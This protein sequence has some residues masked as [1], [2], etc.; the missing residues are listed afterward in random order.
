MVHIMRAEALDL[1]AVDVAFAASVGSA[2]GALFILCNWLCNPLARRLFFLRLIVFLSVA[3]LFSSVSYI[4]SF[5][6]LAALPLLPNQKG[7]AQK[8]KRDWPE[9][10]GYMYFTICLLVVCLIYSLTVNFLSLNEST[11][12]LRIAG[13]EGCEGEQGG[14]AQLAGAI[15]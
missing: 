13:G 3:N 14:A 10:D 1:T 11:M 12:C 7:E 4:M 8:R 9:N 5:L 6:S 15:R 2:C